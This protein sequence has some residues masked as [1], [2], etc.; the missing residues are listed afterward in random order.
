MWR[1]RRGRG[2][3]TAACCGGEYVRFVSALCS[4]RVLEMWVDVL[5]VKRIRRDRD[6]YFVDL[7]SC[8]VVAFGKQI[9][10]FLFKVCSIRTV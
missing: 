4:L 8:T 2:P 9:H 5:R 7:F 6:I 3:V 10:R 1:Q